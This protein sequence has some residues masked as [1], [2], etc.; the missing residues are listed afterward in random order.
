MKR[1]RASIFYYFIRPVINRFCTSEIMT[2]LMCGEL[3]QRYEDCG[4]T[5][6]VDGDRDCYGLLGKGK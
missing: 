5:H 6:L 1:I 2:C 4:Y 3:L